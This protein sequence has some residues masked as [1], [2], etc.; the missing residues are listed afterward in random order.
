MSITPKIIAA[1]S[2]ASNGKYAVVFLFL[3]ASKAIQP[4]P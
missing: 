1:S 3:S 4:E 2:K